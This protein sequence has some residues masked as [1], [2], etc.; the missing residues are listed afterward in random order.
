M[1]IIT[2]SNHMDIDTIVDKR[3]DTD[4]KVEQVTR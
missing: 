3:N 1:V 2:S 4:G